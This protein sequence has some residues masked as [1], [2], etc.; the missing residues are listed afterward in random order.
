MMS[1]PY[2]LYKLGYT[3]ATI[4]YTIRY[5]LKKQVNLQN[6]FNSNYKLKFVYMKLESQ[7]IANQHV[8]VNKLLNLTHTARHMPEMF[9]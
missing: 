5:K 1:S 3:R 4:D 9:F 2:G 7:V 8:A 6:N